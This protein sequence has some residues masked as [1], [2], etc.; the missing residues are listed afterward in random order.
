M[1]LEKGRLL[2]LAFSLSLSSSV[3]FVSVSR[4]SRV[5]TLALLLSFLFFPFLP[6][7]VYFPSVY[8]LIP[9][10]SLLP[11]A[12]AFSP[13]CLRD[14]SI[15]LPVYL[16]L[17]LSLHSPLSLRILPACYSPSYLFLGIVFNFSDARSSNVVSGSCRVE[18][19][20][21]VHVNRA[22]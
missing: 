14:L 17:S 2:P 18:S 20:N 4:S 22:A 5:F 11:P 7:S 3:P 6:S 16:F 19:R 1:R 8:T 12:A 9:S 10:R 15:Y 21:P 13:L